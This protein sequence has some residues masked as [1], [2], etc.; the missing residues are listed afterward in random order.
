MTIPTWDA[1]VVGI[2]LAGV[3]V[4]L[5]CLSAFG[6][7]PPLWSFGLTITRTTAPTT[8]NAVVSTTTQA[9]CTWLRENADRLQ[10]KALVPYRGWVHGA[11]PEIVT[12]SKSP[13]CR[14]VRP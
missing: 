9:E 1:L 4:A 14:A 5:A 13:A 6:Q 12:F 8:I 7:P 3:T 10:V 11:D 2:W